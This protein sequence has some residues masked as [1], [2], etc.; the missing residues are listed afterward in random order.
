[1]W[2]GEDTSSVAAGEVAVALPGACPNML[3][4]AS[5]GIATRMRM[6]ARRTQ[7]SRARPCSSRARVRLTESSFCAIGA[8]YPKLTQVWPRLPE[9][10]RTKAVSI[11][12]AEATKRS[13]GSSA[14]A[15]GRPD[16]GDGLVGGRSR[17]PGCGPRWRRPRRLLCAVS[18]ALRRGG[19]ATPCAF[20]LVGIGF[21]AGLALHRVP[22]ARHGAAQPW[23]QI[24]RLGSCRG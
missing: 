13:R 10:L 7:T 17:P 15:G 3:N 2:L 23:R 14:R 9:L 4:K 20:L 5:T 8:S 18:V 11:V 6:P 22:D 1:M 12:F 19:M 16:D 24:V 21:R